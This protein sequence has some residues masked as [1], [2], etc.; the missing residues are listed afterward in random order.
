VFLAQFR[1][2]VT[3]HNEQMRKN[4]VILRRFIDTVCYLAN[5]EFPFRGHSVSSTSLNNGN[6]VKFLNVLKNRG[7]LIEKHLNFSLCYLIS[8]TNRL[9]VSSNLYSKIEVIKTTCIKCRHDLF[10]YV[11][12]F[13][14]QG[15][16]GGTDQT[17]GGCSLC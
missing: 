2:D 12:E 10:I 16:T 14:I 7:P 1:K 17:S 9:F 6:F 11:I 4:G 15:V 13:Y 3:K 5:Q 8:N